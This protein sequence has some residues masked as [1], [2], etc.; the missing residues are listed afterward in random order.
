M[1]VFNR[2]LI[3][4]LIAGV[5][6]SFLW[7]AVTFWAY[8]ETKSVLATSIIGGSFMLLSAVTGLYFG[9]FVDRRKK[10]TAMLY[11]SVGPLVT[12]VLAALLYLVTPERELLV[13]GGIRF[14]AFIALILG[15]AVVGN[16]RM[17]ALM[18][19]VTLLVPEQ[20]RDRANGMVGTVNGI[21]FAITSVFSG[22][23]IGQLGML[24]ALGLSVA[25]TVGVLLHLSTISIPEELP[26][27]AAGEKPK[28]FDL[29]GAL[30]AVSGVPGLLG[31]I[32]FATFN[33]LLGG[34]FM[35]LTDP[36]GLTL[37]SVEVWGFIW[38]FLSLGF[39]VGG[40]LIARKGLGV[41]PLRT[42]FLANVVMWTIAIL[43]PVRSS[44]VPLVIGFF[45]YMCLIPV[46]Q[47]AEQTIIQAV[48]PFQ[49]QG[50]VF[51]F[52]Q[53]VERAASPVT[54]FLIGPIAQLW[55]IPFMTT[56]SGT[57]LIGRW[58]GVGPDRGMAL[59]FMAAG[60]IGLI[61]TLLAMR[62]RAYRILSARYAEVPGEGLV[63]E[64]PE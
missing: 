49:V 17:I 25:L 46:V 50:R 14:W 55:V 62:S 2:I 16:M 12:Y 19:T 39:I 59:V 6:N 56:G 1:Q 54:A 13:L 31:L 10:K 3:N 41:S 64:T 35:S 21:A 36:Y 32:F 44:I 7:F 53:T 51:G 42:L 47:A 57:R 23:V 45:F 20:G 63:D 33:N 15:G 8:L 27:P 34:V 11:S 22:L 9:T 29:R 43:F 5:T 24:W 26:A 37:V 61:I 60:L 58:F 28:R 18:T 38:G 40:V 48:V 52:A 4:S 30:Q